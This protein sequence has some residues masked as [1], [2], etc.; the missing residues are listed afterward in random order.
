MCE[1]VLACYRLGFWI[2]LVHVIDDEARLRDP[3]SEGA[4]R[5]DL[6][7]LALGAFFLGYL[8]T[9]S[10]GARSAATGGLNG[11]PILHVWG[12]TTSPHAG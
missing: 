6:Q 3:A 9:T 4:L 12:R 1:V 2:A 5:S 11:T 10:G 7:P 8:I